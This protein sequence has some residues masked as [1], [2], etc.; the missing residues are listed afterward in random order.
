MPWESAAALAPGALKN[1]AFV[2]TFSFT[3]NQRHPDR[4]VPIPDLSSAQY[5]TGSKES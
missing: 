3:S 1:S 5:R 2:Q 4:A